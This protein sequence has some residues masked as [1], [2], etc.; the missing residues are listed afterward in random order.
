MFYYKIHVLSIHVL[1]I[2]SMFYTLVQYMSYHLKLLVNQAPE[3]AF[4]TSN[5]LSNR[6][7]F[8]CQSQGRWWTRPQTTNAPA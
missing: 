2:Q 5:A 8:C 4:T 6:R 7:L 3:V 1:L